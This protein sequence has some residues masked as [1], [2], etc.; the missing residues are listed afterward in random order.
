MSTKKIMAHV[1]WKLATVNVDQNSLNRCKKKKL[2]LTKLNQ[3]Y[4]QRD[5]LKVEDP[6]KYPIH[7]QII[8]LVLKLK[9]MDLD[10]RPVH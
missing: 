2:F 3:G 10:I 5:A 7:I 9:K 1:C 6:I 4:L 8:G